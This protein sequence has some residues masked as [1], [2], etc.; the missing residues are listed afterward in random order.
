MVPPL[1]FFGHR[2]VSS[3]VHRVGNDQDYIIAYRFARFNPDRLICH[4]RLRLEASIPLR[5]FTSEPFIYDSM[6]PI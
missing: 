1:T 2:R 3:T 5:H 6:G 4:H